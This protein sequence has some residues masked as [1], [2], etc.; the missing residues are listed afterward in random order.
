MTSSVRLALPSFDRRTLVRTAAWSVPAVTLATVTPAFAASTAVSCT[1]AHT[2]DWAGFVGNS[3][4]LDH[5][6]AV[7]SGQTGTVS[8]TSS[9]VPSLASG[10][11][12]PGTKLPASQVTITTTTLAG[13]Y[14]AS[15]NADGH[16][17]FNTLGQPASAGMGVPGAALKF[18]TQSTN[19]TVPEMSIT[20]TFGRDA[21][22]NLSFILTD[23]DANTS[24]QKDRVW[25]Q[26]VSYLGDPVGYTTTKPSGATYNTTASGTSEAT[27]WLGSAS[28]SNTS[29]TGNLKFSATPGTKIDKVVIRFANVSTNQQTRNNS[30]NLGEVTYQTSAAVCAPAM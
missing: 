10:T 24:N 30:L 22:Q 17:R 29:I 15:T 28:A 13:G 19:A 7:T 12:A 26:E 5:P 18:S 9:S 11:P 2:F 14:T 21:A 4:A 27:A 1:V 25:I 23:I 8:W 6:P 20:M 3:S 16:F